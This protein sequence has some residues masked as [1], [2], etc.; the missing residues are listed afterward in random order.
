[1]TTYSDSG[2]R[3]PA[4]GQRS[5]DMRRTNMSMVLRRIMLSPGET[6]SE[7]ARAL[8]L[9]AATG[10][11]LVNELIEFGLVREL[12]P[13]TGV[14][15]RPGVPLAIDGRRRAVLGIHLGPRTTGV[16]IVGFDGTEHVSVLVPHAGV[17]APE[18]L[19]MVA[20]AARDLVADCP[21]GVSIVGTGIASGGI[22]D[23]RAGTI[24]ENPV[25]GWRDVD[26][27]GQLSGRVPE[28][29]IVEQNARAAAQ[30]EL[31][32]GYG[33]TASS[34]VLMVVTA[35]V[36]SV[37]VHDG[38]IRAGYRQSAGNIAHLKVTERA[39]PCDCGRSGCLKAVAT[40]DAVERMAA[41][42]GLAEVPEFAD[43][44]TRAADGDPVA[45]DV[46]GRRSR[47]VGRAAAILMDIIDPEYLVIAGTVAETPQYLDMVRAEADLYA[48]SA[49]NASAR[50]VTSLSNEMSLTLFAATTIVAAALDDPVGHLS[51]VDDAPGA[52]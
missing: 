9:S 32:Y 3:K 35:D 37:S 31:L 10:T 46:L 18:A 49:S 42:A 11:N 30:S 13:K 51:T 36:G 41:E 24:V 7:T 17:P 8:G 20:G 14:L 48:D 40:D 1:M 25:A 12:E 26:V 15:G 44:V 16:A 50:I 22:V 2:L 19:E 23:R 33:K 39:I 43:I 28:P 6:R 34:F 47:Y 29:I 27:R 4:R 5:N 52:R 21:A 45:A 38:I